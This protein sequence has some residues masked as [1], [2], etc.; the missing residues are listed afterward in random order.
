G[1]PLT[2]RVAFTVN[3]RTEDASFGITLMTDKNEVIFSEV[4]HAIY[5]GG[6]FERG[7]GEIA[8]AFEKVPFLDSRFTV[9]IDVRDAKGQIIDVLEPACDLEIMYPGQAV[10]FVSMPFHFEL[11]PPGLVHERPSA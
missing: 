4:R 6:V 10:G 3:E 11:Q 7:S 1:D 9:N 5:G 8:F 2:I